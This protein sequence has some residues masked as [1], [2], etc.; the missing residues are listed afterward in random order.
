MLQDAQADVSFLTASRA[1]LLAV[2]DQSLDC[3]K[4]IG[5]DGGVQYVNRN[6]LCAMEID[7]LCLVSGRQWADLWP[8]DARRQ[9]SDGLAAAQVGQESRFTAFC[10]TM[11]GTPRWWDVSISPLME[12]GEGGS[13]CVAT[14]RDVTDRVNQTML[15]EAVADEMR[16]RLRNSYAVVGGLL[17]AH[18]RS[19]AA[20]MRFVEDMQPRLS[21][22]SI[23][24]SIKTHDD[25]V[26]DLADLLPRL[27]QG[28]ATPDCPVTFG[29]IPP[30]A[31][32]QRRIDALAVTI[33]ELAVNSIKHGALGARGSIAIDGA[34]DGDHVRLSWSERSGRRVE[35]TER[36]GGQGLRLIRR[37][38]ATVGGSVEANWAE[39][40]VDVAFAV[41]R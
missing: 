17:S 31:L 19:D 37:V 4:V 32:D 26:I 39:Y 22:L 38:L 35:R 2:L 16:H 29:A 18:A 5:R 6:G 8:D 21:A 12:A 36:E 3:I 33:G 40:G 7:D 24:Q 28:Y 25:D 9:I 1:M 23:A 11:K 15:H 41:K 10:P 20:L 14:S 27:A 13:V 34:I 30:V